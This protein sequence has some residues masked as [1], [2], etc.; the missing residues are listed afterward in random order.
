[1]PAFLLLCTCGT[2]L[3]RLESATGSGGTLMLSRIALL[4][5]GL[6]FAASAAAGETL[7]PAKL[8]CPYQTALMRKLA[9]QGVFDASPAFNTLMVNVIDDKLPQVRQQLIAMDKVD[10]TRWRQSALIIA[11]YAGHSAMVDSL[12]D[13]GAMV[14]DQGSMPGL[15]SS[16]HDQTVDDIK[17]DPKWD[18]TYPNPKTGF[19]LD[20]VLMFR[21]VTD[22]PA[23]STAAM[24]GNVATLDILLNHHANVTARVDALESAVSQ[25]NEVIAQRLLD[26]GA[27]PSGGL[28]EASFS[29][30]AAMVGLLLDHG[31]DPCRANLTI[32]KPGVTVASLGRDKGL[33]NSMVRRLA[34]PTAITMH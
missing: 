18:T 1:M 33:P 34:C 6:L 11:T 8:L 12:L 22:G 16:F 28:R 5:F 24:C 17:K 26:H 13:D 30:N 9:L 27:N 25:G 4:V 21:D 7:S 10:A 19:E 32:R 20:E 23:L 14:D 3:L 29:G 2:V 31:A 15:K